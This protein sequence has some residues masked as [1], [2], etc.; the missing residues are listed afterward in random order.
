MFW[1]HDNIV[2]RKVFTEI[3]QPGILAAMIGRGKDEAADDQTGCKLCLI[4]ELWPFEGNAFSNQT[5]M[6][7]PVHEVQKRSINT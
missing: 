6:S 4:S 5:M 1:L 7:R 3:W 2:L